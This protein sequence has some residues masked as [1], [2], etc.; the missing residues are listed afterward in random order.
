MHEHQVTWRPAVFPVLVLLVLSVA[1][2]STTSAQTT[3]RK[4]HPLIAPPYPV[5]FGDRSLESTIRTD[6]RYGHDGLFQGPRG[7]VYWNYLV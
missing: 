1:M 5:R 4:K 3:P 2:S 6:E 7:W